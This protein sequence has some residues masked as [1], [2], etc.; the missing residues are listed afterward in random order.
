MKVNKFDIETNLNLA[1]KYFKKKN[2]EKGS[3]YYE[4]IIKHLPNN[5]EANFYLGSLAA[6]QQNFKK[7]ERLLE[8]ALA[9]NPNSPE[10]NN[11]LGLIY[12][13]L[14]KTEKA[15]NFFRKAI[16]L[17]ENYAVAYNNLGLAY[18][19]LKNVEDAKNSYIKALQI[20]SKNI[21][22]SY[23]LGNLFKRLNDDVTSENYFK[24]TLNIAPNHLPSYNNLMDMYDKSNQT[25]KLEDIINKAE[26]ILGNN[27][28]INLF[29]AKLLFKQKK[30]SQTIEILEKQNFE[31][32]ELTSL[33]TKSEILAKS[34]DHLKNYE[35]AY[36]YF[37]SSNNL[38]GK[39]NKYS[40]DKNIF[41]KSVED[42]IK[43]F[44]SFKT[45]PWKSA[46]IKDKKKDPIFLI[47][48][49][50]SGTTLLDTIL[51][52]HSSI[53]VLEEIPIISK[54]IENYEK[55]NIFNLNDFLKGDK[56]F[57]DQ[58][59]K[60]YFLERSKFLRDKTKEIYIDKMPLNIIHVAEILKFFPNAK[61][62]LALRH[63]YDCVLSC[64]MQNF[65]LNNAMANFLNLEDTSK[66]YN[67]TMK[68]WSKYI[69]IFSIKFHT[70][71]YEDVIVNFDQTIR[72]LLKFLNL[73][74]S[75]KVLD[76][77]KTA[78]KRGIISTPSYNQ[79]SQPIYKS[80]LN[81]WKNYEKNFTESKI[82][83]DPWIKKF[84][85]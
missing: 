73:D 9:I 46:E 69:N 20:D 47:G 80:S 25:K 70:I 66:L 51:R 63:P 4:K 11:N 24:Q 83:L 65:S 72:E 49:P 7:A 67:L 16:Q 19:N 23:N 55:N 53:E 79:V 61:F 71:K 12:V 26:N 34:H 40:A 3:I 43:F 41:I 59:R 1:R 45:N 74:W 39:E 8:T 32:N 64:F 30:Y 58:G 52:S 2:F 22:A 13:N 10:I 5:F 6:Q 18:T 57:I 77:H 29:K 84:S 31:S 60:F 38:S 35:K 14:N 44:S 21:L 37:L 28:K 76:F 50:R 15:I 68:L 42:R 78:S 48:F 56:E 17:N 54:L 62:I 36:K 82:Y 81:R 27:N 33:Q 85:Y 75:D